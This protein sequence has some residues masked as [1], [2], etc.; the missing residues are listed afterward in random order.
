M[1][2][3]DSAKIADVLRVNDNFIQID[4]PEDADLIIF[5]TCS[6]RAKAEQKLFSDL[7]R[8]RPLKTTKPN[9][10][11][12]VG[13]CIASQEKEH[14]MQRAPYV[15]IVFGP[16]T[17]HRLPELYQKALARR[18]KPIDVSFPQIEKFAAFPPPIAKAPTAAVT[19][20]EGCNKFCSYC[21]VPYTRGREICRPIN[22]I[23]AEIMLLVK[24]GVKEVMLLGQNVNAYNEN[25]IKL[26]DL[27]YQIAKI[28]EISRI[29]FTTSHPAEFSDD[30]IAMY[31]KTPKLVNHIHLPLQ[32][33]SDSILKLMRRNYTA[34]DYLQLITKLRAIRPNMSI[35]SDFIVGFPD[36]TAE[37]F[38]QTL[39]IIR[40]INFDLSF[41][42]IY[43]PRKNTPAATFED[44]VTLDEKKARLAKLQHLLT[45]QLNAINQAMIGT[46]QKV[47][48]TGPAKKGLNNFT[49]RTE[50]SRVVNFKGNNSQ[51]GSLIDIKIVAALTNTLRGEI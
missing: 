43:S 23:M 15:D 21:V 35:S 38:Q 47:L 22:D 28:D 25:N 17:L 3:Y 5:N 42:F 33:G 6:V 1:N 37:D 34:S 13:G 49:G 10:L 32:S 8:I 31:A 48:V 30:L 41:S 51:V 16:Q 9:L 20:M 46:T 29:R 24:Q 4:N 39:D 44:S 40:K 36:E 2:E 26:A 18:S 11:I 19:I 27:I 14:I 50:N 45:S 7:G 12:G